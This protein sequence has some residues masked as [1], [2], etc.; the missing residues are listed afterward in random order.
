[1]ACE[2]HVGVGVGVGLP[3]LRS[4]RIRSTI[5]TDSRPGQHEAQFRVWYTPLRLNVKP[6]L[7][8]IGSILATTS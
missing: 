6:S 7:A 2:F 1:V 3:L 4:Q 8:R 5:S